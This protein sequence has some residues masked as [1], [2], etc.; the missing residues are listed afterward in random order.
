[1]RL[2]ALAEMTQTP[3][4]HVTADNPVSS[5]Y[6]ELSGGSRGELEVSILRQGCDDPDDYLGSWT[7]EDIGEEAYT[8]RIDWPNEYEEMVSVIPEGGRPPLVPASWRVDPE[9]IIY[10]EMTVRVSGVGALERTIRINETGLLQRYYQQESHQDEYVGEHPFFLAF[11]KGRLRTQIRLFKKYI[12]P[13]DR[14]LDVGSGYSIFFLTEVD[15]PFHVTCCDLDMAAMKKMRSLAP[16]FEWVVSDALDLPW[17][18]A[19]FDVVYAGEIVEHVPDPAS[20]IREWGRVLKPGGILILSTPNRARL[21]ARANGQAMPVHPEHV[22]ELNLEELLQLHREEGF[23]VLKVT[24]VYLE[25]LISWW[26]PRGSRHDI[27]TARF[28]DPKYGALYKLAMEMGRLAP[29]R[30]FDL[31]LVSRKQ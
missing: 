15:W 26:L 18:D 19:S 2:E 21:L 7:F 13:A 24:G 1:M 17:E 20:G 30:A 25:A 9:A 8:V 11:H 4:E 27:L 14:V 12:G 23:H 16:R 31:V 10:P 29:S 5:M 22:K 6:L 3:R 28:A